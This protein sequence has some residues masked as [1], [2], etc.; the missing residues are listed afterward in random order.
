MKMGEKTMNDRIVE[1]AS[2]LACVITKHMIFESTVKVGE[3][4]A[5]LLPTITATFLKTCQ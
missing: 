3:Y 4:H 5:G 1:G 2:K